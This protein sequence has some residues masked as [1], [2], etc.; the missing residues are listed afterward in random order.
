[1]RIRTMGWLGLLAMAAGLHDASPA[2]RAEGPENSLTREEKRAG[3]ILLFDGKSL[4]GWKTSSGRPSKGPVEQGSINPHSCGGYMMIHEKTW[5]DFVLAL[6][7]QIS[8]GC[9]SGIFIRT[10]P[11]T[12][13]PG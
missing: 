5:S 11:L 13:R 10:Y 9:N 3:W 7:F 6:D 12:P 4:E 2:A 8:K 1:M